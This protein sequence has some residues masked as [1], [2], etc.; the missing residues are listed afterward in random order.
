MQ[1]KELSWY[2]DRLNRTMPLKIYGHR[3]KPCLVIPS[4]DGKHTDF[5]SFGMVEACKPWIE[6]GKLQLF[7]ID[8]I[9]AE[10]WSCHWK[11]PQ[12]RISLHENWMQ[13]IIN[14]V[15]PLMENVCT[16]SLPMTMGCSLGAFHAGNLFF[17]FP[18]KFDATI[19]LSG[20]YDASLILDGYMDGLVYLNSPYHCLQNMPQDHHYMNLYRRSKMFFCVGQGAWED[21][22]LAD[23]RKLDGVLKSKGIP[24]F[25]DYWGYDVNHDWNW[26][27]KQCQYFLDK[28]IA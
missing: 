6:A 22:L 24:A 16:N 13:Y 17:R 8:T 15:Y 20:V 28:I 25:I 12:D 9:D 1:T 26:W 2:S 19:C 7:C 14:E 3:G 27:Q 21:E 5:E 4:Q 23:T 10:T 18:D 11:H